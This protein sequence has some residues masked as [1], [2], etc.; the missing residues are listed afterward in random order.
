MS[1]KEV[2]KKYRWYKEFSLPLND[3]LYRINLLHD[4][5]EFEVRF[6]DKVVGITSE[7]EHNHLVIIYYVED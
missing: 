7:Q 6:G 2:T 3:H 5:A 1:E 4:M